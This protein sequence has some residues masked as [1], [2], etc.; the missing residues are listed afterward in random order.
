MPSMSTLNATMAVVTNR[1][2]IPQKAMR[3]AAYRMLLAS[4]S[5]NVVCGRISLRASIS[6]EQTAPGSAGAGGFQ[7]RPVALEAQHDRHY[8]EEQ[9]GREDDLQRGQ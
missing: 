7:L 5:L 9:R 1:P 3:W 8:S 6:S 4:H 2:I